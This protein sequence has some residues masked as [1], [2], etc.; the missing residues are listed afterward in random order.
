MSLVFYKFRKFTNN[1]RGSDIFENFINSTFEDS[2]K[3]KLK[4]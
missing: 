1:K 4:E 2:N 3:K